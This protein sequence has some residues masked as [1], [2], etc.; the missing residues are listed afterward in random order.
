[1][2]LTEQHYYNALNILYGGNYSRLKKIQK[3]CQSWKKAW[4][5]ESKNCADLNPEKEWARLKTSNIK[6]LL[7]TDVSYPFFLKNA[8]TPPFG[9]Y[10]L[11]NID[12]QQPAVA[13]VGTRAATPAGKETARIFARTLANAGIPIISGLAMG[14]DAAAH[15]GA[16]EV[17]GKTIAVLGTPLNNLYPKQNEN[18]AKQILKSEISIPISEHAGI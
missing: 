8:P 9:I 18:L 14:I 12:Y 5:A 16:L 3:Q 17:G 15:S 11:G 6:F 2:T 1:M 13:I 7:Q 10:V 4:S